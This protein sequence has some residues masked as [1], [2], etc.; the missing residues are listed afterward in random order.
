[1]LLRKPLEQSVLR[2]VQEQFRRLQAALL[3]ERVA[4]AHALRDILENDHLLALKAGVAEAQH[5]FEKKERDGEH[6]EQAEP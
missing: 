1:M 5:G 4:D 3:L 2:V 6:S